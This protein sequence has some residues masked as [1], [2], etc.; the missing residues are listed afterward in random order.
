M[1]EVVTDK[2]YHSNETMMELAELEMRSY[3]P[4][5]ERGRRD[6]QGKEAERAAVYANRRR[7]R[8]CRGKR[9]LK[10]RGE[11]LERSFAYAYETGGLRRV[12]LRGRENI[13]KRLLVHVGGFNLSL[14]MRTL[15]GRGTP[16][17]LQGR[18]VGSL[19]LLWGL[20][21]VVDALKRCLSGWERYRCGPG[22]SKSVPLISFC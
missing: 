16:R 8:G 21:W 9:L 15:V 11:Y 14:V 4:E 19:G 3:V 7:I 18:R 13:L 20:L 5:P 2:G 17:G 10:R 12:H 22:C 6:W 1:A